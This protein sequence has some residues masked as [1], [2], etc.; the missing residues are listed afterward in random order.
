MLAWVATF[1]TMTKVSWRPIA[2]KGAVTD[3]T[4]LP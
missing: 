2:E 3:S 4:S 1:A